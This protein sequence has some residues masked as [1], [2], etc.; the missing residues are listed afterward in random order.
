MIG[1]PRRAG[2]VLILLLAG[3][4]IAPAQDVRAALDRYIASNQRAIVSEL[5]DLVSIPN[6]AADTENIRRNVQLL[7]DLLRRRGFTTEILETDANPLVWGELR[8]PG[9][10]RTLLVWAHYDGQPVDLRAWKQANPFVPVLRSGRLEEGAKDITGVRSIMKFEPNWRLYGR[11]VADDKAPIVALLAAIDG[12]KAAGVAPSS[13]VRV[14]F[15]AEVSS[16]SLT[17]AFPRYRDKLTANLMV[18][19]EGPAHP[20]GRPTVAFGVRGLLALD[21]TVYGPKVGVNSGNYGNWVPNPALR[22]ARLLASMKDDEGRVLVPGFYDGVSPLTAEEQAMLDAVP[23]EPASLMKVLGI[24]APER[25]DLSLQQALQ[26]PA[27]NIR[28]LASGVIGGAATV[29]IPDRATAFLE[30]RLVKETPAK[31]MAEKV[32]AHIRAQ[33]YHVIHSEPDDETRNRY[34]HLV[35]VVLRGGAGD[36]WRTPP[37]APEAQLVT[38][39]VTRMLGEPPVLIRTMGQRVSTP[40]FIEAMG[41][42]AIVLPTVNFDNNQAAEN[43][44]LRLG[45]LFTGILTIAAV[46]TM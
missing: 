8:V 24:A 44:N 36:A 20:S 42:P 18:L 14:L 30:V 31:A 32:L 46:L 2:L 29:V 13:N 4:A 7:R 17:A 28:G 3:G 26:L 11:S 19:L 33:G 45:H 38:A 12:L 6:T 34:P 23:D 22:L 1:Q 39:A 27:L 40:Q 9:A 41:A 10:K 37:L 35:K 15:D 25:K 5:V 21:L 43:E 16:A